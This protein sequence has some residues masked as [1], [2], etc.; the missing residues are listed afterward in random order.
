MNFPNT[1][2][3]LIQKLI[4]MNEASVSYEDVVGRLNEIFGMEGAER[5]AALQEYYLSLYKDVFRNAIQ[6]RERAS[7]DTSIL[8]EGQE[9]V[10]LNGQI[11]LGQ[12]TDALNKYA[13]ERG[14]RVCDGKPY[15]GTSQETLRDTIVGV[16]KEYNAL[17]SLREAGQTRDISLL[18][19]MLPSLRG[20]ADAGYQYSSD[21]G[22][23]REIV[24]E[25]YIIYEQ[26]AEQFKQRGFRW[27]IANLGEAIRT[28]RFLSRTK[29]ALEKVGF[30]ARTHG[31]ELKKR[32][33]TVPPAA[34][35]QQILTAEENYN[36]KMQQL[37]DE[38]RLKNTPEL[39]VGREKYEKAQK[40]YENKRH[41]ERTFYT[42]VSDVLD[43]YNLPESKVKS[44][45]GVDMNFATM[46]R[47]FDETRT[48][49]MFVGHIQSR[50]HDL[51]TTFLASAMEKDEPLDIKQIINDANEF[52]VREFQTFSVLYEHEELKEMAQRGILSY[53][54]HE[55][56]QKYVNNAI[57]DK[58]PPE[59]I[60]RIQKEMQE[61]INDHLNNREPH[62][63]QELEK[64]KDVGAMEDP[65]VAEDLI[66]ALN[67]ANQIE[68]DSET[69]L[70]EVQFACKPEN[71]ER[72]ETLLRNVFTRNFLTDAKPFEQKRQVSKL[73]LEADPTNFSL[74]NSLR[75]MDDVPTFFEK[76]VNIISAMVREA[77]PDY[78]VK[79]L[80]GLSREEV[81]EMQMNVVDSFSYNKARTMQLLSPFSFGDPKRLEEITLADLT[82][83]TKRFD[84]SHEPAVIRARIQET[85]LSK[86]IAE[87]H[88]EKQGF[89]W[90]TF[91][92]DA[93]VL[94]N[95]IKK[96]N[97]T[98]RNVN[99]TQDDVEAAI[100][101]GESAVSGQERSEV[102]QKIA[103]ALAT[104]EEREARRLKDEANAKK[105]QELKAVNEK[106]LSDRFFEVRFRPPFT[107][108]E[109]NAQYEQM[110][111]IG[112]Q[113][114]QHVDGLGAA[115]TVF[116]KNFK[117]FETV[118]S[119]VQKM[120]KD[121]LP[122]NLMQ[123]YEKKYAAIFDKDEEK[124]L[125]VNEKYEAPT[126]EQVKAL[127]KKREKAPGES[128]E[129]K[130]KIQVSLNEESKDNNLS[131]RV[132]PPEERKQPPVKE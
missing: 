61:T 83:D 36:S 35:N 20:V 132:A 120:E 131:P 81:M 75:K 40:Y 1:S 28:R 119:L 51:S 104:P 34:L 45:T 114:I 8:K 100:E 24:D 65:V 14:A 80:L 50:F 123:A 49:D 112:K 108:A 98:L 17:D 37:A 3:G 13:E 52:L 19:Q 71:A 73:T 126:L 9:L 6:Y 31:E 122:I 89:F 54:K 56:F 69:L 121:P 46:A 64:L 60:E 118:K 97:E 30:D 59:E 92:S 129:I 76:Y 10:F 117:K 128:S 7:N 85:Y 96:A 62:Y 95:F 111:A 42:R 12:V 116:S 2:K 29:K 11:V 78:Q 86:R 84:Y 55:F 26:R 93:K 101:R 107:Y 90:K 16:C 23:S 53:T 110:K 99:F 21:A 70:E 33:A 57:K 91:S 130:S 74:A 5:D 102:R 67:E 77:D 68:I 22:T 127:G 106:P 103:K 109:F 18:E 79:P 113:Y 58:Y 47:E 72:R 88:L 82:E 39:T 41:P 38:E 44:L 15:F 25:M 32:L 87:A 66:A 43:K 27:T 63:A 125:Q 105:Q 4:Y 48:T 124:L 115:K 94:R